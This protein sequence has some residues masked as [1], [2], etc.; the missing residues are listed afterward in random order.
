[1]ER[2]KVYENLFSAKSLFIAGIFIMPALIINPVTEYRVLQFLF[3]MFLAWLCGKKINYFL[4]F[5]VITGIIIFNLLV[6]YGRILFSAGPFKITSGALEAGIHRA[7]TFEA[8]VML[9]KV[10]IRKDIKLPGAFG[11]LMGDSL[12]IFSVLMNGGYRVTVKNF[13]ADIDSLLLELSANKNNKTFS[14]E[15]KT[16]PAGFVILTA[17]VLLSWLVLL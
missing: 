17:V 10:C 2:S 4:T 16:K 8:L 9:S 3:F 14:Q 1:M 15:G 7:V 5:S 12:F 13:I 11:K 6:P